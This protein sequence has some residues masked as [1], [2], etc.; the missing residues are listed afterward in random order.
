[1]KSYCRYFA[2]VTLLLFSLSAIAATT[3]TTDLAAGTKKVLLS[4]APTIVQVSTAS[5]G[6]I[7]QTISSLG[8][9]E[10]EKSV[11]LSA[12]AAGLIQS[13]FFKNGQTVAKNMPII[14]LDDKVAQ[15][16]HG[17]ALTQLQVDQSN[18]TRAKEAASAYSV[19]QLLQLKA[20]AISD[21]ADV[22]SAAAALE[23]MKVLAPFDGVLG[24][25]KKQTGDYV[26]AG[27]ALVTLVNI[28]ELKADYN[29]AESYKPMLKQGQLVTITVSAYPNK[30]FYGTVNYISPSVATDTRTVQIQALVSNQKSL[31]SPGM[32]VKVEQNI[33]NLSHVVLIPDQAVMADI[34]GYYVYKAIGSKAVKT[35]IKMGQRTS[36]QVQV[37][38][39]IKAGV[40]IIIAGQDKLED[41]QAIQ[42]QGN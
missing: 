37:L 6:N 32:F 14:Q 22:A 27:D 42:V 4:Q 38:S 31:L 34:K 10:A 11:V 26:N 17:K 12:Q 21:K 39:G 5:V 7:P 29:I 36:S 15:A 28:D 3:E 30:K 35:Y 13:I 1:M 16:N 24:T 20:K 40:T 8:T 2:G 9:L 41:G 33:G 19:Q 23:Q 25:F 18:Y